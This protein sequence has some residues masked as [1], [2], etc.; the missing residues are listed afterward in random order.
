MA[1]QR[2]AREDVLRVE[3]ELAAHPGGAGEDGEGDGDELDGEAEGK[4]SEVA[5]ENGISAFSVEAGKSYR[6]V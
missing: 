1:K 4:E 2:E 5:F 6:F 3:Q